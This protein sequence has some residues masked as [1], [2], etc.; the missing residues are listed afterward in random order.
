M[1]SLGK[2]KGEVYGQQRICNISEKIKQN[3]KTDGE[4]FRGI[5]QSHTQL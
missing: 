1:L 2:I 4:S 5:Y 3:P